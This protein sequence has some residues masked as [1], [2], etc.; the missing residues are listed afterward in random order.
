MRATECINRLLT[1]KAGLTGDLKTTGES[2]TPHVEASDSHI[3]DRD[4]LT[5]VCSKESQDLSCSSLL[6]QLDKVL[7]PGV[8]SWVV[9]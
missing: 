7:C 8:F 2:V 1:D 3:G 9:L 4:G 6:A 5:K